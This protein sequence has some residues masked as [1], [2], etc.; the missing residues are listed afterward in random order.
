MLLVLAVLKLKPLS[1]IVAALLAVISISALLVGKVS[2]QNILMRALHKLD[3]FSFSL[4]LSLSTPTSVL[5]GN[6]VFDGRNDI[7]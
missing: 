2:R 5:W 3:V 4:S 7:L 1:G 6:G